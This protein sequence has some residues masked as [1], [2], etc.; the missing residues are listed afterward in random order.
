VGGATVFNQWKEAHP[1]DY[2][3]FMHGD[4]EHAKCSFGD[5]RKSEWYIRLEPSLIAAIPAAV[6]AKMAVRDRLTTAVLT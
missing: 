3:R 4:W 6:K 1:A 2:L 5:S